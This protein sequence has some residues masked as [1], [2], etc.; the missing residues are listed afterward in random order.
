[1]CSY[2][3]VSLCTNVPLGEGIDICADALYR[4][5]EIDPVI[6][7]HT[8]DS[9]RELMRLAT[10]EVEFSF[11]G[12]MYRQ[13]DG[14]AMGSPLGPTLANIFVSFYD[15]KIPENEWPWMYH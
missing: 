15:K 12:E 6:T 1:M 8:E 10:S 5:D 7:T 14:V 4:N 9:F 2:D 11:N 3:V 13:I